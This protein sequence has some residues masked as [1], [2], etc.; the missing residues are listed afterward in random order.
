MKEGSNVY[1][2][3]MFVG[4]LIT[5]AVGATFAGVHTIL[6]QFTELP[7]YYIGAFVSFWF[8]A[9]VAAVQLAVGS[10]RPAEGT[11]EL[12]KP[13]TLA[14]GNL[15]H[16]I[17]L[18]FLI[19]FLGS[20]IATFLGFVVLCLVVGFDWAFAAAILVGVVARVGAVGL[21]WSLGNLHPVLPVCIGYCLLVSS[22]WG[23]YMLS[24]TG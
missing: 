9:V 1:A 8:T 15:V 18:D 11:R 7:F 12:L 24:Y 4:I 3:P 23:W 16:A 19:H 2:R 17:T 13:R 22:T 14:Q 6:Q 20:F 10:A 5:L 21:Y